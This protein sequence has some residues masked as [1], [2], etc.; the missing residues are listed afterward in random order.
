MEK[1]VYINMLQVKKYY[2]LIE[3]MTEQAKFAYSLLRKAL[4]NQAEKQAG[5]L[6]FLDPSNKKDELKQIEDIFPQN[7]IN[8]L[9]RVR[10]KEIVNL[11]DIIKTDELYYKSKR[12]KILVKIPYLL[13]FQEMYMK[14]ICH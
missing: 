5:T 10:L 9:I 12:T 1:L 2:F 3:D 14:N 8:A 13:L 4:R 11:Q 6:K 7:L